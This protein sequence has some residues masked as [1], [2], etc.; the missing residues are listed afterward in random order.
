MLPPLKADARERYES[1]KMGLSQEE[2]DKIDKAGMKHVVEYEIKNNRNPEPM[3]HTNKGYDIESYD[4]NGKLLRFI[5]VKSKKDNW[6]DFNVELS[7]SQFD[8]AREKGKSFYLYVVDNVFSDSPRIY[9][10]N[11]PANRATGYLF[12]PPWAETE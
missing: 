1:R 7:S 6:D 10:I 5:E 11:D 3:E 12:D 8:F 2:I 4:N 9:E